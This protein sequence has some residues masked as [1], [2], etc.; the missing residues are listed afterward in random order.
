M[1][2]ISSNHIFKI[3]ALLIIVF[4]LGGSILGVQSADSLS[5]IK[6]IYIGD[7]GYDENADIVREKVRIRLAKSSRFTIVE[8]EENADAVLMGAVRLPENMAQNAAVLRLIDR[9]SDATIWTFEY[10]N[11]FFIGN[12]STRVAD[13]LVKKLLKDVEDADKR[14]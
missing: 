14:K 7:F 12:A 5:S 2:N 10:K 3:A 9:K 8:H 4:S 6:K 1:K 13:Q 11:G